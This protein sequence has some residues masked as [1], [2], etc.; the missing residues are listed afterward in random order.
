M[1]RTPDEVRAWL[2]SLPLDTAEVAIDSAGICLETPDHAHYFEVGLFPEEDAPAAPGPGL[3]SYLRLT[4][5][6]AYDLTFVAPDSG[7]RTLP[8]VRFRRVLP[9]GRYCF[10][11]REEA[12]YIDPASV[13]ECPEAA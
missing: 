8:G 11:G 9:D 3:R 5:G 12:W 6:R 4:P 2:D 10:A 1:P 7:R 13:L